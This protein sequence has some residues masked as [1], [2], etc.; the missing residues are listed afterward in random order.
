MT[1][2]VGDGDGGDRDIL[3]LWLRGRGPSVLVGLGDH[4]LYGVE[5]NGRVL[6]SEVVVVVVA[7][8]AGRVQGN[9]DA[10]CSAV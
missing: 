8:A 10:G 7:A 2:Y 5:R 1:S 4:F 3:C 9:V 6:V